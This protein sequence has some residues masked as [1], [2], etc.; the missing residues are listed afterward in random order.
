[1]NCFFLMAG[2][3]GK[4]A[5]PLSLIRPK[6]LFPLNGIPLID[7][8]IVQLRELGLGKGFVNLHH[9]ADMLAAHLETYPAVF[10]IKEPVL[11]G[12]RVLTRTAGIFP[13][14]FLLIVNADVYLQIPYRQML[15]QARHTK[16]DCVLLVKR[17]RR[18]GYR[19]LKVKEGFF[20]RRGRWIQPSG[21]PVPVFC[22]VMLMRSSLLSRIDEDNIFDFLEKKGLRTAVCTTPGCWMDLGTPGLYFQADRRVRQQEAPDLLNSRSP[23]VRI[24]GD[25]EV[26]HS[27]LWKGARVENSH[28]RQCIVLDGARVRKTRCSRRIILPGTDQGVRLY[29][30]R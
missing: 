18:T 14:E 4:R 8:M 19:S 6:A 25:S 7:R 12:N 17:T 27:I 21:S 30:F 28:L 10:P 5:R 2:G 13:G 26:I 11:T 16:A 29:P 3:V 20:V 15:D 23:G 22:G 24:S 9:H 1:M